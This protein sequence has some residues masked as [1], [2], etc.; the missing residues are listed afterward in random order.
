MVAIIGAGVS[1][2]ITAHL[3]KQQGVESVI[4]EKSNRVGGN[5]HTMDVD[6]PGSDHR[7]WADMGVN[8]FNL[9]TYKN[10]KKL[11]KETGTLKYCKP[12]ENSTT[13]YT[14]D[15]SM[16]YV[17]NNEGHRDMPESLW[18]QYQHF[19]TYAAKD[20]FGNI[21]K[22][23]RYTV[24]E[25]I[26]EKKEYT[27]EFAE[28]NLYPRINGMYYMSDET[29]A[30]MPIVAVLHYY[31]LQEGFGE[32]KKHPHRVYIEGGISQWID[33]FVDYLNPNIIYNAE[34]NVEASEQNPVVIHNKE[35]KSFDAVFLSTHADTC[36]HVITEG[37]TSDQV[38]LLSS[39]RYF[40]SISVAH[41]YTPVMPVDS[42]KQSTYNIL[43]HEDYAQ[44]RPYTISYVCNRHQNDA[45]N[46]EYNK[47]NTTRYFVSLNPYRRIPKNNILQQPDNKPAITYMSHNT[48]DFRSMEQQKKL[49]TLQ[50]EHG[51]YF[52]GGWTVGAGLHEECYEAAQAAVK[53]YLSGEHAKDLFYDFDTGLA[54][55]YMLDR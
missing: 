55:K 16:S 34:V 53:K 43:I 13:F 6:I 29:P 3:L 46:P 15:G 47:F 23:G 1:G 52:S 39:F 27:E 30:R 38:N 26:A 33:A 24:E 18:E 17:I 36:F 7:R 51:L 19:S 14:P 10:I 12:L 22:Y 21:K 8:D 48:L 4:F 20:V 41:T 42:T 5:V 45:A 31:K 32:Q 37:L 2:L 28:Y 49:H 9:T 50:G 54:P 25:Y 11:F 35:R 40:D 44:L